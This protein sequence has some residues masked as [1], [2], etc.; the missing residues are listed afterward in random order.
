MASPR[1]TGM[2]SSA[3]YAIGGAV[4]SKA[5]TQAVLGNN[6]TGYVGYGANLAA[7]FVIGKVVG[8]VSK[9]KQAENAAILGGVIQVVSRFLVDKTPL[10]AKITAAG[11]GDYV[12]QTT[13]V[14]PT[15]IPGSRY[16]Y[17]T[18]WPQQ[19]IAPPPAAAARS[20]S[21]LPLG[22]SSITGR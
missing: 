8:M 20:M 17:V 9:N 16:Q 7:A 3:L 11:F 5:L 22:Y 1:V 2:L 6:N 4:G 14:P 15:L 21:G 18:P 12:M 13:L 19:M 10:G